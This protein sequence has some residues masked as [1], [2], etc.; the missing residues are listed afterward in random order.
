[1]TIL[2]DVEIH[3]RFLKELNAYI[4]DGLENGSSPV[5]IRKSLEW[6]ANNM[7]AQLF[8]DKKEKE[9]IVNV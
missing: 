3:D 9:C 6:L 7:M 1:M 2:E 4:K 8:I 5:D